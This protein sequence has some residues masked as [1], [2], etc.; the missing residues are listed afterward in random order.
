MIYLDYSATAPPLDEVM[1]TYMKVAKRFFANPSSLHKLGGEAEQLIAQSRKQAAELLGVQ[2]KEIIFTSGGSEGNN[3]ALKGVAEKFRSRGKHIITTAVEHPSVHNTCQQLEENG[4]EVTYLP[5]NQDGRV[6]LDSLKQAIRPDTILVSVIHVNNETGTIQPISKIGN[7]LKDY[8]KIVFHTDHVQGACKVALDI[9]ECGIDLCTLSGHKF[10]GPRGTGILYCREGLQLAPLINGGGQESTRRSG[11]EN[12]AG[13]AG[14]VKALRIISGK[15]EEKMKELQS[16]YDKLRDFCESIPNVTM[17]TPANGAAPHILN[18]TVHDIKAEVLIHALEE[19][20][21]YIST[22]SACSS[23][24]QEPSR[25]L[26]AMGLSEKSALEAVRVSFSYE[27]DEKDIEKFCV[28]FKE[29]VEQL[30]KVMG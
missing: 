16:C 8:P 18:M 30:L 29:T 19:K 2:S 13:I 10:H 15:H 23:K 27:I 24:E 4:F 26:L 20:D 28:L 9:K 6:S 14:M 5:V 17:N 12:T 3:L 1:E 25:V 7:Y 11:T 22:K 21:I